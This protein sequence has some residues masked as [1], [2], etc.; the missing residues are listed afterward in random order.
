MPDARFLRQWPTPIVAFEGG[1]LRTLREAEAGGIGHP[2]PQCGQHRS[3][4]GI[5]IIPT[6]EARLRVET[7]WMKSNPGLATDPKDD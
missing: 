2:N 6:I 5:L 4:I 7:T 1:G 3:M